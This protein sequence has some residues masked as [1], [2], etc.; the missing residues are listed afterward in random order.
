MPRSEVNAQFVPP[1]AGDLDLNLTFNW[2]L[3][4]I[5]QLMILLAGS[6]DVTTG[7]SAK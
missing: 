1:G 4:P 2:T 7:A 5:W 3:S 6:V